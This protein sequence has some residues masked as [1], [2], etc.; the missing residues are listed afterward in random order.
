MINPVMFGLQDE[1]IEVFLTEVK[2]KLRQEIVDKFH[3]N[4]VYIQSCEAVTARGAG[5]TF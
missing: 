3:L 2:A 5:S 4:N 1:C